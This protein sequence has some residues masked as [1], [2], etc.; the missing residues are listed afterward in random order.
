ME[1]LERRLAAILA[2]DVVKYSS[3]M[4]HDEIGTL[5]A[6]KHCQSSIIEPTVKRNRGR[7]FKHLGDGYLVEF[8]SAVD[9]LKCALAWQ[10]LTNDTTHPLQFRFG[11]NLGEVISEAGDI[12]G[13]GV[14]VAS[15]IETLAE[16]GEIY[17]SQ[18]VMRQVE[19]K[20]KA[21]FK[22]DNFRGRRLDGGVLFRQ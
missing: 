13:H 22:G 10:R 8:S 20:V 15:R 16:P 19:N 21:G 5:T 4:D 18:E 12:F 9:C 2:A 3:L 14:N 1:R 17:I 11:I 6:L 7:I